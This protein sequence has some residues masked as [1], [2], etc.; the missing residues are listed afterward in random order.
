MPKKTVQSF[1]VEWLQILDENGNCDEALRPPLSHEDINKLYGTSLLI[2]ENTYLELEDKS[3]YHIRVI[4]RV[5]VKGKQ[6]RVLMYEVF[7]ADPEELRE[8][9]RLTSERLD[10]AATLFHAGEIERAEALFRG[11]LEESPNDTVVQLYLKRCDHFKTYMGQ[12]GAPV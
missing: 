5:T 2:S 1:S 12:E 9:K 3:R 6:E 10:E 11:L 4:D 7:D 8:A